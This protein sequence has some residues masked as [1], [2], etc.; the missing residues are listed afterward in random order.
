MK[1]ISILSALLLIVLFSASCASGVPQEDYDRL[2]EELSAVQ[3]QMTSLQSQVAEAA[4]LKSQNEVLRTQYET[5]K[6]QYD[7]VQARYEE[8]KAQSD[9]WQSDYDDLQADYETLSQQ[10]DALES[11]FEALQ[12]AYEELGGN[13]EAGGTPVSEAAIEQA[14]FTLVNQER[15]AN[16]LNEMTWGENVYKWAIGNS[17]DME[18]NEEIGYSDYPSWQEVFWATGYATAEEVASAAL[19][20]WKAGSQYEKNI[21][22]T[23]AL[24]GAVGVH[25]A[26]DIYYITYIASSFR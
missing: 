1:K 12:A 17:R 16:G 5:L 25:K 7:S 15:V 20:I 13:G 24:Y 23:G 4:A 22:S 19:T 3:S 10:Y 2:S 8:L 26:R 14:I 6:S 18:R 11:E 9:S 21:L